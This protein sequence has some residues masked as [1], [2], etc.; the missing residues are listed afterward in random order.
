LTRNIRFRF[1]SALSVVFAS[2]NVFTAAR[3]ESD[4]ATSL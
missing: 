2:R 4:A 3:R 1:E